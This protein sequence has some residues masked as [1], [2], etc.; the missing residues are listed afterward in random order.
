MNIDVTRTY[1]KDYETAKIVY[2]IDVR[3]PQSVVYL[4]IIGN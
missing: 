3:Q 1:L 2:P 4:E